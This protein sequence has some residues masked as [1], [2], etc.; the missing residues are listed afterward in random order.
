MYNK[1]RVVLLILLTIFMVVFFKMDDLKHK[2][3]FFN[4]AYHGK[5]T[6][7]EDV[8]KG[9]FFYHLDKQDTFIGLN[10]FSFSKGLNLNIGD[11][12]VKEKGSL[13]LMVFRNSD[14]NNWHLD[15]YIY[16]E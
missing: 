5:I 12:L 2:S 7:I 14:P 16:G 8:G 10:K 4:D 15:E 6:K 13:L 11:S 1:V 9:F 3:I